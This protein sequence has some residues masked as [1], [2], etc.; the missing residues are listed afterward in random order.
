M[1]RPGLRLGVFVDAPF[2]Q[3]PATAR[4][5]LHVH[6]DAYSFLLF[7]NAVAEHFSQLTV[8]G[9]RSG[10]PAGLVALPTSDRVRLCGLPGYDSLRDVQRVLRVTIPTARTVWRGLRDVDVLWAMGP[11]PFGVIGGLLAFARR[12]VVVLGVRQETNEYFRARINSRQAPML[13][14]VTMLEAAY[15]LLGRMWRVTA[16][17]STVARR[18]GAP[19]PGVLD[20]VVAL[21][22]RSQRE[23][24][25]VDD[26]FLD[27]VRLLT[28]GR[29]AVD[30]NPRLLV[31]A[32]SRLE[33]R[34]PGRFCLAWVGTGPLDEATRRRVDAANLGHIVD[35]AGFIPFGPAL[36]DRYAT[37]DIF[38][39][40]ALTEGVPQV[41]LEAAALGVPIVATNVGG[42][43]D[44]MDQGRCAVLVP[45]D[46]CGAL[47]EAIE[48]ISDLPEL[49]RVIV[50]NATE[51]FEERTLEYE[52]SRVAGFLAT[53]H[54]RAPHGRSDES[55]AT[56]IKRG[57]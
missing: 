27:R 57:G 50:E 41:L 3:D 49:R 10:S 29:I 43:G 44:A 37:A 2:Y 53:G 20:M 36:L 21:V 16:V 12:R 8:F 31:E 56:S 17:G 51:R 15:R 52:S 34:S 28:V 4:G 6:S 35:F 23:E 13:A 7:V 1:K 33:R 26:R 30:K 42:V 5:T 40:V 45:P 22:R 32:M 48:R 9:R 46:D 47:V 14:L 39:H 25:D 18:Y 11:H 55:A 24:L 54:H 38:V 19:R